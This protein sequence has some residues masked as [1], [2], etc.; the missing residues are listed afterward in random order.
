MYIH[1]FAFRFKPAVTGEQKKHILDEIRQVAARD[2]SGAGM[3][4]G[5]KYFAARAGD[6]NWAAR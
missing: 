6:M 3:L 5:Q 1:M 2:S 4:G